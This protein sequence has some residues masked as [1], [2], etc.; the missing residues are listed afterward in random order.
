MLKYITG[1]HIFI[2]TI[3]AL[4]IFLPSSLDAQQKDIDKKESKLDTLQEDIQDGRDENKRLQDKITVFKENLKAKQQEKTTLNNQ[5]EIL[6]QDINITETEVEQ[7]KSEINTLGFEIEEIEIQINDSQ[8]DINNQ[9]EDIGSLINNLYDYDQQT[10][11]EQLLTNNTLSEFANQVQYTEEVN[12]KFKEQLDD[13]QELKRFYKQEKQELSEK[14]EEEEDKQRE[15]EIRQD[16]LT[17]ELDYKGQLLVG[18][19]EDEEKFQQLISDIKIEQ[20]SINSELTSLEKSARTTLDELSKLKKQ[21]A[22]DDPA[23]TDPTDTTY[24]DDFFTMP[25]TFSPDWPVRGIITT[26]FKDPAYIFRSA[27][28]HDAIDIAVPQ[29]TALK[30]ADSGVVAVVRYDGSSSYAW[31][32]IVHA[33][34]YSSFYGHVSQV[35]VEPEQVVQKGE[36]IA[37]TGGYPGTPGAGSYTTGPHVHFGIRLN[38]IAVDP[39]IYLP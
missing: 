11:L 5:I 32:S 4:V 34:K 27:F 2:T 30:A 28:E 29:G 9:K 35:Y 3:L 36:I 25:T 21:V 15:L 20:E 18:V 6:D 12:K 22:P 37:A 13:L 14:K 33:D 16:S 31:I 7:T 10:Y 8:K 19:E 24:E 17:G 1:K 23:N 38:G 39:L 26:Y